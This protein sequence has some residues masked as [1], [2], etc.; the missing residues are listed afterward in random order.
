MYSPS[1]G[2]PRAGLVSRLLS[3]L[4][5]RL[6]P[7]LMLGRGIRLLRASM[8]HGEFQRRWTSLMRTESSKSSHISVSYGNYYISNY[9]LQQPAQAL[10]KPTTLHAELC[11][12]C[13]ISAALMSGWQSAFFLKQSKFCYSSRAGIFNHLGKLYCC[14]TDEAE[15]NPSRTFLP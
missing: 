12:W 6:H 1:G 7:W 15:R 3:R 13:E 11:L 10:Y 2:K 9:N 5:S 4:V 14:K 8:Q